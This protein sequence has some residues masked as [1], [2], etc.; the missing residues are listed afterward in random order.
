MN[1]DLIANKTGSTGYATGT[2][3]PKTGSYKSVTKYTETIVCFVKGATFPVGSDGRKTT[4]NALSTTTDSSR[5]SF[6]SVT[7]VAG[8]A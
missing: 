2:I 6:D 8:A 4:W 1:Q 7:A 3:C 5:T